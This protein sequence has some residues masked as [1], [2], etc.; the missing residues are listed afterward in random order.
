MFLFNSSSQESDWVLLLH[1]PLQSIILREFFGETCQFLFF[2][3]TE[4]EFQNF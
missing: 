1:A 4:R 3:K 2:P